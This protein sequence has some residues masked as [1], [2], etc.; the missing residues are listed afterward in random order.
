MDR[1]SCDS[2]SV[3]KAAVIKVFGC[4]NSLRPLDTSRY[5]Y[6][7]EAEGIQKLSKQADVAIDE[8]RTSAVLLC[9]ENS[10]S[11]HEDEVF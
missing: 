11:T 8:M 6:K 2:R 9:H 5:P 10:R 7:W 1:I 3:S 4:T